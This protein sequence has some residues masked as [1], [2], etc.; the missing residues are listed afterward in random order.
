QAGQA[1]QAGQAAS[2]PVQMPPAALINTGQVS[3]EPAPVEAR[4]LTGPERAEV[5]GKVSAGVRMSVARDGGEVRLNLRPEHLGRL[6]IRLKIDEKLVKARIQVESAAVKH[7]LDSDSGALKEIFA[8]SGLVLDRYSV[9][10]APKA[11]SAAG[12]GYGGG[13]LSDFSNPAGFSGDGGNRG[14]Y[15]KGFGMGPDNGNE[16]TATGTDGGNYRRT[17]VDL[18]A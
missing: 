17:G 3:N 13:G 12:N 2:K 7:V 14:A 16:T 8:K 15:G 10:V 5:F 6:D 18:F 11:F 4:P 1:G 9:E